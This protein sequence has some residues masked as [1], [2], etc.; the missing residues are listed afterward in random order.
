MN[1]LQE[2]LQQL[3]EWEKAISKNPFLRYQLSYVQRQIQEVKEQIAQRRKDI[4]AG[5]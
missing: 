1:Q 4:I 3:R 5:L 2:R